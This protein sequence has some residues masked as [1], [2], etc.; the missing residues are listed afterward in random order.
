MV[1]HDRSMSGHSMRAPSNVTA[2]RSF[3]RWNPHATGPD[4]PGYSLSPLRDDVPLLDPCSGFMSAGADAD[5]RT[6][7]GRSIPCL[8]DESDVKPVHSDPWGQSMRCKTT[9]LGRNVIAHTRYKPPVP[10]CEQAMGEMTQLIHKRGTTW[11]SVARSDAA[12]R[13]KLG[14]MVPVQS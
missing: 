14:G 11:N 1:I 4:L 12:L 2:Q 7:S 5:L 13:A 3:I 10:R 6:G 9:P 8:A